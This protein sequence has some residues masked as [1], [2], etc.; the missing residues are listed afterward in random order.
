[1]K[2]NKMS[3]KE[4]KMYKVLEAFSKGKKTRKQ[5]EEELNISYRHVNRLIIKYNTLGKDGFI[6]GNKGKQP[7]NTLVKKKKTLSSL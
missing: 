4:K 7:V 2:K 3:E 6:H 1:M 5:V